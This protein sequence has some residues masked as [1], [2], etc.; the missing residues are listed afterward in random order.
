MKVSI[1]VFR[2]QVFCMEFQFIEYR[3]YRGG[4]GFRGRGIFRFGV[5]KDYFSLQCG[6]VGKLE[7]GKLGF[8]IWVVRIGKYGR[9]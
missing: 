4:V 7:V 9:I 2:V 6:V 1:G 5:Y 8:K 3:G